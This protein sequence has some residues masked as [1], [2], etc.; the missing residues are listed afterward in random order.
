M[1]SLT[2]LALFIG[3]LAVGL[4]IAF[5]L[6]LSAGAVIWWY[7]LPLSVVAQR[8][9][10][11][12]DSTPL[13]AVPMFIFAAALFSASG[14]TN[15]LFD[16]IRMMVG[17]IRGGL[18]QVNVLAS[19]V[20]SGM[21]GAALADL[22]ALGRLQ[23]R[24]MREQGYKDDFSAGVTLGAATI[25][26]IFP[27]SIPLII[28]A[29]A[30]E[31]SAVKLLLA[32]AVPALLIAVL[33]MIQI[34]IVARIKDLPRDT[35]RPT[36]K[37]FA[38]QFLVS[39][40]AL[41]APVILIGGLVSGLFGPTE[42]A[43][44]TVCYALLL[45]LLVYRNLSWP[46]FVLAARET[47]QSTASVLLIVGSAALFAWVLT[48]DRVPMVAGEFL[49]ALTTNPILLLLLVNGLLLVL[50]MV[51]ESIA[52]ILILAP[53]LTPALAAVGVDPVHLGVVMVLN[54]MIGLL[55]PP[56]GMSLYMVSIISGMPVH[57]VVQGTLPFLVPLLLALLVVTLVPGLS[58]WLPSL[59]F[60]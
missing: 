24:M 8:T 19:L 42:V 25:G 27:P 31:V 60:P 6:G 36:P 54:L 48:I 22:G 30:A 10:N 41:L 56:V 9:V 3:F 29:T 39:L 57:R 18:A 49:L 5:A 21:S 26:P 37:Q 11:A 55:T 12:L 16:L 28:F 50:G 59:F 53:I 13:L 20:F 32:G 4:P 51:L 45:G 44:V 14:I 33:L 7:D 40:P 34:A 1:M 46:S 58:T 2:A 38:R 43:A 17:R 35:V 52:A 23:I 47:V 15:H